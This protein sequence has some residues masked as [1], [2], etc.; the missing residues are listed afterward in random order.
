MDHVVYLD[1]KAKEFEKLIEGTKTMIIR[2]ATGR[3]MPYER[4]FEGDQ[5]YFIRNNGEGLFI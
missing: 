1:A 4:V 3:K 5:L 2:G